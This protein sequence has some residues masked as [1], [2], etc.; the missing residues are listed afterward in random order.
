MALTVKEKIKIEYLYLD[1]T[2]CKRCIKTANNLDIAIKELGRSLSKEGY[3]VQVSK[4]KIDSVALAE[5]YEFLTSPTI[6]VNDIDI[7]EVLMESSCPEC[8]SLCGYSDF[9]CRTWKNENEIVDV[10]TVEMIVDKIRTSSNESNS[11]K[12]IDPYVMPD[13]LKKFFKAKDKTSNQLRKFIKLN[14]IT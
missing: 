6:R 9:S 1:L 7:M 5:K 3:E 4:V 12:A 14:K 2:T 8:S 10:P 13:N 11:K